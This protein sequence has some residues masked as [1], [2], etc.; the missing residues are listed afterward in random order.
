MKDKC[1]WFPVVL[2][3]GSLLYSLYAAWFFGS[4]GRFP[5]PIFYDAK[6]T[7]GDYFNTLFWASREGRFDEWKSIYPMFCFLLGKVLASSECIEKSASAMAL[8][9][10]NISSIG[11]LFLAYFFGAIFAALSITR[12]LLEG[13][14]KIFLTSRLPRFYLWFFSIFLG[15]SGLYAI[16]RGNFI[17]FAFLF[18]SVSVFSKNDLVSAIFLAL[19]ISV[20]QYLIVLLFVPFLRGRLNYI[21]T[22]VISVALFNTLSLLAVPE[23][24]QGLLFENML[25]FSDMAFGNFFEKIW[26]PTSISAWLRALENSHNADLVLN[27]DLKGVAVFLGV[28]ILWMLRFGAVVGTL[29]L[30]S[31]HLKHQND[32]YLNFFILISAMVATD[33]LAGYAPIFLF[34]YLGGV[35]GKFNDSRKL[36][37]V[38]LIFMP[39]EIPV[40]PTI[41]ANNAESYLSGVSFDGALSV[42]IGAYIRPFALIFVFLIFLM[43]IFCVWGRGNAAGKNI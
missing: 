22:V 20:K 17:V 10:C 3:S 38:L 28:G 42:T 4:Y 1:F 19:A 5:A 34:P 29:A 39:L 32:T 16:E 13:D 25:G 21:F 12:E 33:S 43:D 14:K 31:D 15:V 7:F 27:G 37:C 6:D 35:I 40:W 11:F 18:V 41:S 30:C 23:L 9:E 24:H 2:F 8:R 26:N 36:L